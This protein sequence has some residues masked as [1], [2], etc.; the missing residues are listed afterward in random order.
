MKPRPHHNFIYGSAAGSGSR[1][2]SGIAVTTSRK[3]GDFRHLPRCGITEGKYHYLTHSFKYL[4]HPAKG[5]L[6]TGNSVVDHAKT[7]E[8]TS[9]RTFVERA[10]LNFLR[11]LS[12][13]LLKT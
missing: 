10:N 3:S 4:M 6:L 5:G 9:A 2:S 11:F 1:Q 7:A 12:K 8:H 13:L